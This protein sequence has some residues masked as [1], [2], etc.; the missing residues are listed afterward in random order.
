[1]NFRNISQATYDRIADRVRDT[2]DRFPR[3]IHPQDARDLLEAYE[4]ACRLLSYTVD[5]GERPQSDKAR[6]LYLESGEPR[7]EL[8]DDSTC[9]TTSNAVRY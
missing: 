6:F 4:A 2:G 9:Q 7:V 1:M 8:D 5:P 3:G